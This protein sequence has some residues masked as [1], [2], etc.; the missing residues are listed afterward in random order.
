[1][2]LAPE[3]L[4]RIYG[5]GSM[6]M[7]ASARPIGVSMLFAAFAWGHLNSGVLRAACAAA[8][9]L[10]VAAPYF[11][12]PGTVLDNLPAPIILIVMKEALLGGLIGLFA[13]VPFAI[14]TA[15]GGFI[16]YYRGAFMGGPD[17]SGGQLTPYSQ[18]FTG[19]TLWLFA[20]LGGFWMLTDTIYASYGLWPLFELLPAFG[21]HGIEPLMRLVGSIAKGALIIGGP[22][23]ILMMLSD[24]TF[25]VAAKL[26]KQINV[27]FLSFSTK[28]VLALAFLP[29]FS[30]VLVRLVSGNLQMLGD[31]EKF[32]RMTLQ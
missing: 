10:P 32:L 8:I 9:A 22:L 3:D 19:V 6:L 4:E 11:A 7:L 27:T 13:T 21:E 26:G 1:M 28:N 2:Q 23:V 16:D 12:A 20:G 24:L 5:L 17:P 25:L 15:G 29:L 14:A 31:L 30:L 18:L